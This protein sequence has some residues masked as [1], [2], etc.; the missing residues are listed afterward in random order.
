METAS[1]SLRPCDGPVY[2]WEWY[3]S[4][5]LVTPARTF[6]ISGLKSRVL[7]LPFLLK[8]DGKKWSRPFF[9]EIHQ[10]PSELLLPSAKKSA[11]KR[12]AWQ[13]GRYLWMGSVNI[14][15][16]YRPLFTIIFKAK[17]VDFKTRD[18]SRSCCAQ[19]LRIWKPNDCS[20]I[21]QECCN[22]EE[23]AGGTYAHHSTTY[24]PLGFS[25]IATALYMYGNDALA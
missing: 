7:K 15:I 22:R 13:V 5:K 10:T 17:N 24:L 4:V 1:D 18:F 25:Y 6:F 19:A 20:V 21:H 9:F 2:V 14:K 3:F 23:G 12:L 8:N 11:Q 16:N